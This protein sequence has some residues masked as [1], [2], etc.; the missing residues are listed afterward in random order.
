MK[1]N[2]IK[3]FIPF[4][5][6]L[7]AFLMANQA[8]AQTG[9]VVSGTVSDSQGPIPAVTVYEKE[10]ST[11]GAQTD[12]QGRFTLKLKGT[13]G[14]IV[15]KSIGFLSQ[16]IDVTNKSTVQVKLKEDTKGLEE[17]VVLG[18][19]QTAKKVTLTG[20]VSSISGKEIR[21]SPSASLQNTLAGRLP[22]FFSQQRGGQPGKDGAAFQIRG[23]NTYAGGTTPLIIV[24]DV[25]FT[26]DQISQIDPNEVESVTIL[27]DASTTAVYGVR[28]ANGVVIITTRRGSSGKPAL[29]FK[30]ETGLQIPT[31]RP[32]VNDGYTTLSLFRE[33]LAGQ[34]TNPLT[35][36]SNYFAGNNL[37]H[38][39]LNDDP[40]NFPNV[41]WWSEVMK[42]VSIQNRINF[43]ISGGNNT[44]KY[45]VNL[46]YLYQGGLFKDFSEGQGYQSNY[47]YNRYNFRSN[48]DI[49]PNKT[50]KIKLDLSGRFGITNEPND[51]P[52]NNGGSTFQY[53]WN[54]EL[55]GFL[56]PIYWPN[57]LIASSASSL[58]KPNP[59]ANLM[60]SGYN[61][62]YTNNISAVASAN[63]QLDFITKGLSA[64]GLLSFAS[65]YGFSRNLTRSS[66]EILAYTY[67][68]S[69][70]KYD[71]VTANLYR[72]GAL[73]RSSSNSGTNRTLN[74]RASL[75]YNRTFGVHNVG[76][77]A[78]YNQ[79]TYNA[80]PSGSVASDPYNIKGFTGKLTY[81][82]NQ[83]YLLDL[84]A[85]Y[86]GSD[87]F[88]SSKRFQWF[89][90]ASIGWNI[91][92][93][94]FF[95]NN[96]K[97]VDFF[98]LRASYGLTGN[99]NIG[100]STYIYQKSYSTGASG[101]IFG[102]TPQ[103]YGG[104]VEPTLGNANITWMTTQDF[105]AGFDLKL[106]GS[107][108][109]ITG[110]YFKKI[111]KDILTTPG[112]I[113]S[114]FGAS[115][116]PYNL[117]KVS[118]RGYELDV[119]YRDK[120]GK[121]F[122]FFVNSNVTYARNKVEYR[123]EPS[124]LYPW[125][126]STGKPVGA[127]FQYTF[128]GFYQSLKDLYTAPRVAS[129]S[130]LTTTNLGS[131]KFK[132]LNG[133]GIIDANDKGYIGDNNP[134]YTGGL[135]IGFS[136]KGFDVSTL[137]QGSFKYII[138]MY[139]GGV[140]YARPERVSVPW[141]A[142][143]WTPVTADYAT[144]PDLAGGTNGFDGNGTNWSTLWYVKG[145]YIRWKQFEVG[146]RFS[147]AFSKKLHVNN[148]RVY[149]NGYNMGLIYTKLPSFVD[150]ES[151]LSTSV[152]EYPQQR[153][154]NFGIQFGL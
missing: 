82:Y 143:R 28:G 39:R 136:Y 153:V 53:L 65:D 152:G 9:K 105:D 63:Q 40:Y 125:L 127:V 78:L 86:N 80:D 24:D 69:T 122:T 73:T 62:S 147:T 120:I 89:P 144:F 8:M 31:Q 17:V 115:L 1:T 77:V 108:L 102:E 124:Y 14:I 110:D 11:N 99:D 72:M 68:P 64:N 29:N 79:T 7:L 34:Y 16:E 67:T 141:N 113:P 133:D 20:S 132:D 22:G 32:V 33:R 154:F 71:P 4:L 106:F 42:K 76:A 13:Q 100:S 128:D 21:Q 112:L 54:G 129:A 19:G 35:S 103:S 146:Y 47:M 18:V 101:I 41:D 45:F 135:S 27:K 59:V 43:D 95:K 37:E 118:N 66:S 119:T 30:N 130:L 26:S 23:I 150:P 75:N 111:T 126:A 145:D 5:C 151:A 58:T 87:R 6:L 36:Y 96:I 138:N 134:N 83:K 51:K 97:F 94:D 70:G 12:E 46:G 49:T 3:I 44:V 109:S 149:A 114:T 148:I 142:S 121:D 10:F 38:Y 88:E 50:L 84:T 61:R 74:L 25:E 137:F 98:K 93:E 140:T 92:E 57:G 104:I 90:A 85:A 2:H 117:G 60:Y 55:S 131:A 116:P 15:I 81:A 123:D 48:V 139:R 91:S 56:Y 52:W 107:R